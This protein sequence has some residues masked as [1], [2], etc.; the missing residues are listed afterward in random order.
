MDLAGL[1]NMLENQKTI[2][3]WLVLI[4]LFVIVP[5]TAAWGPQGHRLIG[6]IAESRLKPEVKKIILEKFNIKSLA[7]VS[8]WAD[9][10]RKKHI[11]EKPWHYTN[12]KEG[13]WT[14]VAERDCPSG[15][16]VIEKIHEFTDVL[17]DRTASLKK[18]KTALKYLVHFV[19]DLHQPLHMGNKK[20]RGGGTL[21]FSYKGK[22]AS[23][24]YL[25]DGGLVDWGREFFPV[26]EAEALSWNESSVVDWAN[27]S[28]SLALKVAYNVDEG[29]SKNYIRRSREV[30]HLRLMQAGVRL[31]HLL[32]TKL[33]F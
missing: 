29:L 30:I 31:G 26:S 17:T 11:K 23:L 33:T 32:N 25:W 3:S 14:Y 15:A 19:G 1:N 9:K 8:N 27:E 12:I 5:E 22:S 24:H 16:C 7:G 4:L 6:N 2:C 21:S 10:V 20:D 13:H 28:R 18:R